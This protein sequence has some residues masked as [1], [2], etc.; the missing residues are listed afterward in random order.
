MVRSER[1]GVRMAAFLWACGKGAKREVSPEF[2]E[3]FR[4]EQME[5]LRLTF[6]ASLLKDAKKR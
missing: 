4:K 5:R 2:I 1:S 6:S 3:F